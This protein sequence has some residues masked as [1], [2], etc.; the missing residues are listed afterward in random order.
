ME[1]NKSLEELKVKIN[2]QTKRYAKRQI[3]WAKKK[4]TDW[5]WFENKE[6]FFLS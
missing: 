6:D 3:T 1:E 5:D 2:N 4:M